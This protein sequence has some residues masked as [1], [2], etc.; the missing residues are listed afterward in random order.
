[1]TRA[2][3]HLGLHVAVPALVA[4]AWPSGRRWTVFII[5]VATMVVDVDHL[6][7]DPIFDPDRCSLA[8][9]PLHRPP[10]IAIYFLLLLWP[11]ARLIALGL[12]IHMALDGIDCALMRCDG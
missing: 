3:V 8:V 11:K 12:L 10:A 7:A 9:H 4:A 1:M 5:L 6:L 2:A